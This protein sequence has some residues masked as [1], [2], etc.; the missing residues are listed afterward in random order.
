MV[1]FYGDKVSSILYRDILLKDNVLRL[2]YRDIRS[3]CVNI[4]YREELLKDNVLRLFYRD[5]RE[6]LKD[7]I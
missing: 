4:L 1:L 7:D 3:I 2:F 5:I 6:S